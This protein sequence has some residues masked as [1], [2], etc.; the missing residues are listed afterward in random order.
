MTRTHD[1]VLEELS[2][3]NLNADAL[4]KML[5]NARLAHKARAEPTELPDNDTT[6]VPGTT[7]AQDATTTATTPSTNNRN[8]APHQLPFAQC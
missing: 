2:A 4:A 1:D 8:K 3:L 5:V 6:V 7:P